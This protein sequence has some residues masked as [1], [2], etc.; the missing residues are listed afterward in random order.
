MNRVEYDFLYGR[1]KHASDE[2][3]L[4]K[5][6]TFMNESGRAVRQIL[7]KFPVA[8]EELIVIYDDLDLDIGEIR[9]R[10]TRGGG[11]H[12][13][14]KSIVSHIGESGFFGLRIGIGIPEV[15]IQDRAHYVLSPASFPWRDQYCQGLHKSV[16]ALKVFMNSGPQTAM[17]L[18]NR[19]KNPLLLEKEAENNHKEK[20]Q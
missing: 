20:T 11:S 17:K 14:V 19:K 2:L 9:L 5:P 16:E 10:P 7:K 15:K 3:V 4:A 13:G 1:G 12:K 6:L 8:L 18:Y